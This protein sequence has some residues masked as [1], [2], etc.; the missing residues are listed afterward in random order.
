MDGLAIE[1]QREDCENL[2]QFRRRDVIETYVDQSKSA[3]DRTAMRPDY[4]RMVA[5]YLLGRFDAIICYDLDRL[6]RQPRQLEDWIDAAELRGLALVTANGDADL[7]TDGGRMYA[8]IKAAV[9]RAEMERKS[10]R[11]SAAQRQRA[12]KGMRPLGYAVDG[13]VIRHE[14]EAVRAIYDLF[15]RVEHP[16]SLRSL[17]RALSGAEEI[18]GITPLPKHTHTVSVARRRPRVPSTRH[19]RSPTR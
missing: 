4:D 18:D 13:E 16:E 14:A 1:R 17:A 15:M 6:T 3:T 12:P 5:D 2:A 8:R 11:Q 7:S 10:A 9:A 19:W